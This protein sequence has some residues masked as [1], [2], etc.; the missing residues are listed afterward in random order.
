MQPDPGVIFDELRAY[1]RSAALKG[2]IDL[3]LFTHI[4]EGAATP[5]AIAARAGASE[6]GVRILCDFLTVAG[7]LTKGKKD[8]GA[9]GYGLPI[10]SKLFL[11]KRSPTYMGSIAD[12]L[13]GADSV[14]MM[15]DIAAVVRKGG[16]L[17]DQAFAPE[18][19]MWVVFARA[20]APMMKGVA[21]A[22]V[23]HL[24]AGDAPMKVLDIAAGHGM[25]GITVAQKNPSAQVTGLDWQNVL[26]VA[27]ENARR[28][29]WATVITPCPA[30]R[31][32][33]TSALVMT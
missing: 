9:D 1:V 5:A 3:D 31:S 12:F 18:H 14:A 17:H 11:S 30:A 10:N 2:A 22:A 23:P 33:S 27:Q 6:R 19:P 7:H 15:S 13:A 8:G 20:M 4:D 16:A 25:Y 26:A 21:E 29:A 24:V 32:R 28:P